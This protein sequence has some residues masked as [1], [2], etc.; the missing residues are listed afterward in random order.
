MRSLINVKDNRTQPQGGEPDDDQHD[1]G[2]QYVFVG[3]GHLITTG[4]MMK[5]SVPIIPIMAAQ[6]DSLS[7]TRMKPSQSGGGIR[8]LNGMIILLSPFSL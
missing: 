6:T 3:Q 1:Q 5:A 4:Q 2:G 7:R 8:F